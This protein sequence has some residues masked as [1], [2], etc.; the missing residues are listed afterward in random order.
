MLVTV[1]QLAVVGNVLAHAG[2][3]RV[4]ERDVA[5]DPAERRLE[6]LARQREVIAEQH[7]ADAH[8]DH[9]Q[10]TGG[11][12]SD[13]EPRARDH[14]AGAP[15][16]EVGGE[17]R[18]RHRTRSRCRL[19]GL[20][21]HRLGA[22]EMAVDELRRILR[23]FRIG[24]APEHRLPDLERVIRDAHLLVGRLEPRRVEQQH[25]VELSDEVSYVRTRADVLARAYDRRSQ[26]CQRRLAIEELEQIERFHP[27]GDRRR[28]HAER[29]VDDDQVTVAVAHRRDRERTETGMLGQILLL[30]DLDTRRKD[31]PWGGIARGLLAGVNVGR[32]GRGFLAGQDDASRPGCRVFRI[33][34]HRVGFLDGVAARGGGWG[35]P[36]LAAPGGGAQGHDDHART[37]CTS[38]V[39]CTRH[40][41]VSISVPRTHRRV[42][43]M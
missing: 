20:V 14:I 29:I 15:R 1:G 17:Q 7:V 41:E 26:V 19:A 9:A 35:R 10:R 2:G 4:D 13:L 16:V 28:Q 11:R 43:L 23:C 42:P 40:C 6:M 24:H 38:I 18:A 34:R 31:D 37:D 3:D 21:A 36:T 32:L 27:Q 5:V 12:V 33:E 8:D 22:R 39:G 25:A 30:G